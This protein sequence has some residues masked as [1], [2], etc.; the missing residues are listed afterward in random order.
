MRHSGKEEIKVQSHKTHP[1]CDWLDRESIYSV[2]ARQSI[3]VRIQHII[4]RDQL[5]A[6]ALRAISLREAVKERD[7]ERQIKAKVRD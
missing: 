2:R 5:K 1:H 4:E 6:Y 7:K 3:L